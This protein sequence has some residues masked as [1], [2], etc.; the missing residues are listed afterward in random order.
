MSFETTLDD[1]TDPTKRITS[2]QL[3]SLSHLEV[4]ERQQ[5]A[6][7]WPQLE[8]SRRLSVINAANDIAVDNVEM[9]F[10]AL[11]KLALTDEDFEV[12]GAGLRGLFEY[13]GR[14]LI[15]TL[16][17]LL[18]E[19]EAPG[20]RR[21]AAIAL[22]RYAIAG[23]LGHLGESDTYEVRDAL[24]E[25]VEDELEEEFV[26]ASAIEAVGA[27]SGEET[28][29]LIESI[30]REESIGLKVGAVDAM[31]RSANETWLPIV[32]DEM[33]NESPEMRHAA[34]FAAGGI[35]AEEAIQPLRRLA[36][37]DPDREVQLAAIRGL[38]EIGGP[39]ATVAL[40]SI[41]YEGDDDLREA[42]E[43]AISEAEFFDDPLNPVL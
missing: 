26:R 28:E 17:N 19:D 21:E 38:G 42:V 24:I 1:L 37:Q 14:D 3:T 41:L 16:I 34:A 36:I 23:E 10:D 39:A 30:F 20:V 4:A 40:K 43:E 27:I 7:I 11:F 25:S 31:G 8:T 6:E 29:N 35:G 33:E 13:E 12:R 5:L 32:L 15:R 22:G 9:N 18:R 2:E